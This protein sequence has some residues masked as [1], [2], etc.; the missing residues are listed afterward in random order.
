[1]SSDAAPDNAEGGSCCC[2]CSLGVVWKETCCN[3]IAALLNI[4]EQSRLPVPD[5][6]V[7]PITKLVMAFTVRMNAML[8]GKRAYR[9]WE[10]AAKGMD[11]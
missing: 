2:R 3:S 5:S 1:M 11:P 4:P 10:D 7:Q 8:Q 6:G 9:R